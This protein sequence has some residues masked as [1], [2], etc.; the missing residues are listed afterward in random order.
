[1]DKPKAE[2]KRVMQPKISKISFRPAKL[3]V[4]VEGDNINIQY[5]NIFT[6][7]FPDGSDMM[8]YWYINEAYDFGAIEKLTQKCLDHMFKHSLKKIKG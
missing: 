2:R 8:E 3:E 7:V 5:S 4:K 6:A 1:M